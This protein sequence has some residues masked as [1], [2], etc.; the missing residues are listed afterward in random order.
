[1]GD[2]K[3][4]GV[5][6]S[7]SGAAARGGL[8]LL[9]QAE[10]EEP[11]AQVSPR[12]GGTCRDFVGFRARGGL[13]G[14]RRAAGACFRASVTALVPTESPGVPVV[15]SAGV[16]LQGVQCQTHLASHSGVIDGL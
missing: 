11:S 7:P 1:M 2:P 14:N 5:E 13:E 16:C 8:S 10:S 4:A 9:S 3:E 6:S 15:G 12:R